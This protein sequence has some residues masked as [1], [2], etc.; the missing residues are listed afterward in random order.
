MKILDNHAGCCNLT[1]PRK[2]LA[3]KLPIFENK[4]DP[5]FLYFEILLPEALVKRKENSNSF[6]KAEVVTH[7]SR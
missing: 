3:Q 2:L 1:P 6:I 5:I 4:S 7:G